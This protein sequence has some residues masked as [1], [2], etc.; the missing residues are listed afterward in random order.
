MTAFSLP[1]RCDRTT[2]VA[3]LPELLAISGTE[4][5]QIDASAVTHA[6]QA[7]LQ[8]LASARRSGDGVTI[9]PS[10]ALLDAAE[11]TGLSHEL[12]D[13]VSA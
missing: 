10:A 6:G 12:F 11:L 1:A 2:V 9:I 5:I 3:L 7:L 13:E 8:L 4:P